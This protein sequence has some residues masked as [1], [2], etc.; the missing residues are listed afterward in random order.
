M[1]SKNDVVTRMKRLLVFIALTATV[2]VAD[3]VAAQSTTPAGT[4]TPPGSAPAIAPPNSTGVGTKTPQALPADYVIGPDDVLSI[5]FWRE[6]DM[7]ADVVVRPDGRISIPVINEVV[8]MGLTPEQLRQALVSAAERYVEDPNVS[9][10]VKE[11]KSRRVFVM[12]QIGK[13]G[14][15]PLMGPTTVMQLIALA[16]GLQE[17]AKEKEIVILRKQPGAVETSI[18]FNYREVVNRKNLRQNIELQP[19]DTVIVP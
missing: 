11:I 2:C 4:T 16:G 1:R 18:R 13:P 6:N 19:G 7:S 12:G 17:F 15:Y 9:V 5:V 10:V 3:P 14:P 8:A